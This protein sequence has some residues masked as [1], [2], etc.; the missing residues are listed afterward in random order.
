MAHLTT[1]YRV[2][3][4]SPNDV[5][6]ERDQL[7]DVISELNGT[8]APY[9]GFVLEL[10]RWETHCYPAMGRAQRVVTRQLGYYDIFIGIMWKCFGS[11]TGRA[12][13]GT[14]EE[15]R[16]AYQAW[17]RKQVL[18]VMFYFCQEPFMPRAVSEL[19]QFR[20][21]L[22]FKSE[23]SQEMLVWEFDRHAAFTDLVRAQLT[24]LLLR[25]STI[26]AG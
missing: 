16:I 14:A 5:I 22:N 18:E 7:A 11:P 24:R 13:S 23:L 6:D 12:R 2:F 26:N 8:I 3:V 15:F 4:A 1:C 25:T 17:R 21:V 20:D 19:D 9:H 10:L